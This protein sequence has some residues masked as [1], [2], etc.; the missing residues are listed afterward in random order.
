M[1]VLD[2]GCGSGCIGLSLNR[3]NPEISLYLSDVSN[4]ALNVAKKNALELKTSIITRFNLLMLI[5]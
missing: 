1:N 4:K 3:E 5:K 2:L